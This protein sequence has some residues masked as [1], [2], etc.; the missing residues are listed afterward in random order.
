MTCLLATVYRG[1]GAELVILGSVLLL[2]SALEI[3][4]CKQPFTWQIASVGAWVGRF[5]SIL[6][7]L[8]MISSGLHYLRLVR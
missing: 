3:V 7:W 2:I 6:V 5:F 8:L 1:S 4:L